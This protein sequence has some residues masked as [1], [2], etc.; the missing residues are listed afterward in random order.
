MSRER[1]D[2]TL[3][4]WQLTLRAEPAGD[5]LVPFLID[6]GDTPT[7]AGSSAAGATLRS[8]RAEHPDPIAVRAPL[9]ALRVTLDV[10]TGPAAAL[11]AEIDAPSGLV[12]LR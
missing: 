2:G 4:R 10:D 5:G 12:T 1:P 11:I 3:L 8:L 6:W 9:D 7:P